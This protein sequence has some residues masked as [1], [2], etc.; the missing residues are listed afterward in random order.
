MSHSAAPLPN[1]DILICNFNTRHLIRE[2]VDAVEA[3]SPK[4]AIRYLVVDNASTDGSA[5]HIRTEHPNV[6]LICNRDN[7]GFG[8]ANNQLVPMVH[9]PYALL[10]NT[11]AFVAPDTLARTLAFME[12]H[13]RC[14]VLGVK[15]LSRDGSLQPSCRYFPTPLNTFLARTGLSRWMP[16]IPLADD[17]S[18]DHNGVRECD[19]VPGCYYLVR[20]EVLDT[21]GLFDPRYFLYY[22]EVD[23]C[24]RVK[25]AGWQVM[26][27]GEASTVHIGGESAKSVGNVANPARQLSNLQMESE[28]LYLR[29]HHGLTGLMSHIGL[30]GLAELLKALNGMRKGRNPF[31]SPFAH[32]LAL[33]RVARATRF[34]LQATR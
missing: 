28:T 3:S 19:W 23:H 34:G 14:G 21:V 16:C 8:R 11:D 31:P 22:E 1:V 4:P 6:A 2:M 26:Y 10:L 15:L 12:A 30:T 29:K 7:V 13:P 20:K 9:A 25:A 5:E 33:W 17:M 18:W 27:F 32:T 24:K